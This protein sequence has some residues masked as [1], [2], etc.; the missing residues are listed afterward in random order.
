MEQQSIIS[1]DNIIFQLYSFEFEYFFF[2]FNQIKVKE[3]LRKHNT[4][5]QA[6][7]GVNIHVFSFAS[8]T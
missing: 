5:E 4:V 1:P 3:G 2:S 6:E 7:L 8:I